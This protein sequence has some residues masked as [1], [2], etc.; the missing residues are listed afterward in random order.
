MDAAEL[1]RRQPKQNR[2]RHRRGRFFGIPADVDSGGE[3]RTP[4]TR[5]MMD[6]SPIVSLP[7]LRLAALRRMF[8]TSTHGHATYSHSYFEVENAYFLSP[9]QNFWNVLK[10]TE[11]S[12]SLS[13]AFSSVFLKRSD[14]VIWL[15]KVSASKRHFANSSP[16]A[17]RDAKNLRES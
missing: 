8:S 5:I 16:A 12:G 2:P 11:A 14:I 7:G 10:S 9:L 6:F 1:Y 3:T 13:S 17:P 15:T 4:N